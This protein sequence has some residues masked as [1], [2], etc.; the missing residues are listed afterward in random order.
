M[1]TITRTALTLLTVFCYTLTAWAQE[2]LSTDYTSLMKIS[3]VKELSASETHLYVLSGKEGLIV[4]RAYP[5]S[6]QWLYT[7][8]GMQKRGNI[9]TADSRFAYLFGDSRRLT[10]LEP[11]SVLGVYSATVLPEKPLA[12]SRIDNRLFLALNES[13][14]GSLSL[15]SPESVDS[16]VQFHRKDIFAGSSVVDLTSSQQNRQLFVLTDQPAVFVL[17]VGDNGLELQQEVTLEKP[18]NRIF[19]T[20]SDLIAATAAG[21]LHRVLSNG[22]GS[23]IT[24]VE[25][26]VEDL[27]KWNRYWFV[28]GSSNRV[29]I[30]EE[31]G[32]LELWKED[33]AAGNYI[34]SNT[35]T[36]WISENNMVSRIIDTENQDDVQAQTGTLA[37]R[38]IENQIVPFPKPLLL[39][40]QLEKNYP[41]SE[42]S[43]SYRSNIDN[44]SIRGNGFYWQPTNSQIGFNRF[45]VIASHKDGQTDSTSFTVDVR[46]FNSPPRISPVRTTSIAAEERYEFQFRAVDP[47]SPNQNLIRYIG[48]DLPEG[49]R[50]EE[51]SGLF[52]W[53]PTRR[54]VGENTFRV[55][56]TD[57]YGAASSTDVTLKVIEITKTAEGGR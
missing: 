27:L 40:L 11:T 17:T 8:E 52:T 30:K 16:T 41:L 10:V 12:A 39:P 50:I 53:T 4:F 48:V 9:I 56:A 6:L 55:I 37:I 51:Q 45:T 2:N 23:L 57:Q 31:N 19:A 21:D 29:W 3:D 38:P 20:G 34:A 7:S 49:A 32:L 13:G 1:K 42:V 46:S 35:T 22:L 18:V 26:P 36:A 47:E 43:F 54:Q 25:E 28:R 14:L 33:P 15:L 24:S 5:D 44:A